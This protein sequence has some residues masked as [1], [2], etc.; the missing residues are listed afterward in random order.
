MMT[1]SV[2]NVVENKHTDKYNHDYHSVSLVVG[3][4][5]EGRCRLARLCVRRVY[6]RDTRF[7]FVR[8]RAFTLR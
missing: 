8:H 4:I 3:E 5:Q 7:L 1:E 2:E 6:I